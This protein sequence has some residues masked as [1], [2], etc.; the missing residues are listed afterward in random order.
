MRHRS[1]GSDS[2]HGRSSQAVASRDLQRQAWRWALAHRA[3]D[4][5]LPSGLEIACQHGQHKHW[6]R[7]VKR[8]GAAGEFATE[9]SLR[10]TDQRLSSAQS[11]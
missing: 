6:G 7:L 2:G 3:S 10:L 11:E 1:S 9:D 4:G 8:A 5:S